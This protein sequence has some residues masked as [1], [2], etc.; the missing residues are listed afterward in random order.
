MEIS[1]KVNGLITKCMVKVYINGLMVVSTK[2]TIITTRN[3]ATVYLPGLMVAY[4]TV[5]GLMGNSMAKEPS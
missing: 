4:T 1:T 5:N 3:K 2:E